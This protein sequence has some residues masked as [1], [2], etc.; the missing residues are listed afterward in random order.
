MAGGLVVGC[1]SPGPPRA[2]SLQLPEPVRDLSAARVGDRVELKFTLPQRTT[3]NLP[4][5]EAGVKASVCRGSEGGPCVAVA[6]L[7]NVGVVDR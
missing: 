1:A 6:S 5:R 7:E 4:I 2:P 3:D